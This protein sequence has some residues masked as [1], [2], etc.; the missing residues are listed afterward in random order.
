MSSIL[1]PIAAHLNTRAKPGRKAN[2][3]GKYKIGE[4]VHGSSLWSAFW[5]EFCLED[6]PH[7]RCHIPGDG[8]SAVDRHWSSLADSLARNARVLDLGCG[9]GILGRLLLGRR[10]DL[11]VTGI[12]F[13]NVPV[14]PFANLEIHAG[15]SMERL[16]FPDGSFDAATSLFGI[17]YSNVEHTAGE[18][19][20]V[21]APG[22][23]FSFLIH[24]VESEIAREGSTRRKGLRELLSGKTRAAFAAGNM[25]QLDQRLRGVGALFPDE[26]SVRQFSA[27]LRHNLS[28]TRA[29]RQ[30]IWQDMLEGLGPEIAILGLLERSAKS[31]PQMGAW[32]GQILC[33]MAVVRV[34]ILRR[35]SGQPIA[36][37]LDGLR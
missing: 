11:Q 25:Q 12:D 10:P 15:V 9:A 30:A 37:Q 6:E 27:H 20:R 7:E 8:Q 16:P 19:G 34:S 24:H 3:E 18:L 13:A 32:M 5:R 4:E 33:A 17:E 1:P 35:S 14:M 28:R 31:A 29:E 2:T 22:A 26:L 36:W 23:R 21:L